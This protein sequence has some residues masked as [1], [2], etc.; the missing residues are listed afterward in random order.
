MR[1]KIASDIADIERKILGIQFTSHSQLSIEQLQTTLSSLN[2]G[3][4][5]RIKDLP[6]DAREDIIRLNSAI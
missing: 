5:F 3:L 4:S 6:V 2:Q 1:V